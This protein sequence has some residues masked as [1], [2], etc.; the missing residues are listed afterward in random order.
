MQEN[1]NQNLHLALQLEKQGQLDEAEKLARELALQYR[2]EEKQQEHCTALAL[3][4]RILIARNELMEAELRLLELISVKRKMHASAQELAVAFDALVE[5]TRNR[6]RL[7]TT[8][9][10][11]QESL[12]LKQAAFGAISRQVADSLSTLAEVFL[13]E[14]LYDE[15]ARNARSAYNIYTGAIGT[16]REESIIALSRLAAAKA[17]TG[18]AAEAEKHFGTAGDALNTP[19]GKS[20]KARIEWLDRYSSFLRVQGKQRKAIELE[21]ERFQ[22]S[23]EVHGWQM[24]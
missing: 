18:S 15:A 16:D 4:C 9:W 19:M 11:I 17:G 20:K 6:R 1:T 2:T 3:I 23:A 13:A 14:G 10:A 5:C 24:I 12:K 8:V 22:L 21:S 7:S